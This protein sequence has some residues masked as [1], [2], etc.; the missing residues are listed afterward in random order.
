ML[1]LISQGLA[2]FTG[3]HTCPKAALSIS[4]NFALAMIFHLILPNS[5]F[6]F[7]I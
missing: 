3:T 4:F 1:P 5:Y 2:S 7:H 6:I